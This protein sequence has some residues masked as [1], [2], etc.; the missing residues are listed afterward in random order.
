MK[1]EAM[2]GQDTKELCRLCKGFK[3]LTNNHQKW[4][5]KTAR[6]LLR[7]QRARTVATD[8]TWVSLEDKNG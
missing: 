8:R 3:S 7:I 1:N 4:V 2:D 6:W 5:L